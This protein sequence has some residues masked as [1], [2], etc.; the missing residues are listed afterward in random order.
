MYT[1]IV[2]YEYGDQSDEVA[3]QYPVAQFCHLYLVGLHAYAYEYVHEHRAGIAYHQSDEEQY[4]A[5][6]AARLESLEHEVG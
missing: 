1:L 5:L 4:A 2:E 6:N 3:Q